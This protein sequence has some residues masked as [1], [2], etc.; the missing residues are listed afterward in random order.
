MQILCLD[1]ICSGH[2][3]YCLFPSYGI[4]NHKGSKPFFL[5]S[6]L[7]NEGIGRSFYPYYCY[8]A[9]LWLYIICSHVDK[10]VFFFCIR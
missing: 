2:D 7:L 6:F 9:V 4:I 8:I 1:D 3:Y 10:N 5:F